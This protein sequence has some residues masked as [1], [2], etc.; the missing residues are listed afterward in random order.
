MNMIFKITGL[1]SGGGANQLVLIFN[2]FLFH[3]YGTVYQQ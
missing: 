2:I 3:K 1:C